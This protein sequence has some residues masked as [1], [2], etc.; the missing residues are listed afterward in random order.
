MRGLSLPYRPLGAQLN[1]TP[2]TTAE[3]KAMP[4]IEQGWTDNLHYHADGVKY[5]LARGDRTSGHPFD[6]TV[7]I[8]RLVDGRWITVCEYNGDYPPATICRK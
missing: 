5:W 4:V 6:N 2:Y 1:F 7:T 3:L 8:E